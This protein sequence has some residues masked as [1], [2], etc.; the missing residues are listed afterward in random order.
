MPGL[1]N[2]SVPNLKVINLKTSRQAALRVASA[3]V[4]AKAEEVA[5]LDLRRLSYS[6]DFFVLCSGSS[7]RRMETIADTIRQELDGRWK[8]TCH[9]EGQ[10]ESGW[11][12]LDYG[13]VVAHIFSPEARI[14]YHLD[15]LWADAPRV[16]VPRPR[17]V[18][19]A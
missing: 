15:R 6:F 1:R 19:P 10:G 12:C 11:V 14:F 7:D 2:R 9:R 8:A 5:V 16:R 13:S 17:T 4:D 18:H 3:A